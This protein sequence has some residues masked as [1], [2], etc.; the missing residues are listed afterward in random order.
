MAEGDGPSGFHEHLYMCTELGDWGL[1]SSPSR[2]SDEAALGTSFLM[3]KF[4]YI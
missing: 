3:P 4:P 2:R 1:D